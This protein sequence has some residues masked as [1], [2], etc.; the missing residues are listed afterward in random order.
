MSCRLTFVCISSAGL[1]YVDEVISHFRKSPDIQPSPL[2]DIHISSFYVGEAKDHS[3][4][5]EAIKK[6]ILDSDFVFLDLMGADP[7]T[8]GIIEETVREYRK[9]LALVGSGTEYLRSRTKL[10]AFEFEKFTKMMEKKA[11]GNA[12][13]MG[14]MN[15]DRMMKMAAVA[16][17]MSKSVRGMHDWLL[18]QRAWSF[19]GF[20]NIRNMLL[21]VLREY[22]GMTS[23]PAP[24]PI[25][26]YS[27]VVLFD[28]RT[29][30]GYKT[31][32]AFRKE[33][34]WDDARPTVGLLYSLRNYPYHTFNIVA[35]I[36]ERLSASWNVVPL[37]S[38]TGE[39][40]F[41]LIEKHM[42]EGLTL[43]VLWD[44][45]PFR[46]GAGPMGGSAEAGISVFRN[47][48]VPVLHPMFM[49]RRRIEEWKEELTGFGPA[50]LIIGIMLPEL[51]G[52]L[53]TIPIGGLRGVPSETIPDLS[54]LTLIPDR[55]DKFEAK[56][57]QYVSLGR[58][59][60]SDKK[61]AFILY[62]Y[63]P[64]EA[65]VGGG[66]FLDTFQ[67]VEHICGFLRESGYTADGVTASRL[68]KTFM[69]GGCCNS[70]QW[71]VDP[72]EMIFYG[73]E[74]FMPAENERLKSGF[75]ERTTS[76]WGTPTGSIMAD[77]KRFFIPG[78]VDGNIFIGLQPSRG[79]FEEPAKNYHDKV[80]PPQ[81]QY[82]AFYQ[83][84]K[85]EFKADAIIHV[86][87]HGTLEF[88]P[89]KESGMC[90]E[91]FPDYLIGSCPHFYYYYTGNPS[92]ATIAKRRT[93][94][95]LISYSGP[96][97]KRSGAYGDILALEE[98]IADYETAGNLAPVQ[99]KDLHEKILRK[100]EEMKL[101]VDDPDDV[102]SV[103]SELIRMKTALMPLGLHRIG[104]PFSEEEKCSFIS[105]ILG[106]KRGEILPLPE[107]IV[108]CVETNIPAIRREERACEI[109]EELVADHCFGTGKFVKKIRKQLPR[110][111]AGAL[112]DSLKFGEECLERLGSNHEFDGLLKCLDG[113]YLEA[114][115]GGDV[116]RDPEVF[117]TGF[118]M[119][120]F[121]ARLVPSEVAMERGREIAESTLAFFLKENG[122][123]PE[124]VS[125]VLWGLETSKTKGESIGQILHYLGVKI[126]PTQ[127][128]FQKKFEL[129]PLGEMNRPRIDVVVTICG[130]FRDMF[131][132]MIHF[133]DEVFEAVCTAEEPEEMNFMKKHSSEREAEL[134]RE[135]AE[136]DAVT[137]SR[138]R[139]FG[140]P[141]GQY[142][143]GLTTMIE[144]KAWTDES[145]IA[146]GYLSAQKH[147]YTRT[148][149][150]EA[151]RELFE[152]NLKQ[153]E[154]VSQ[155]RSSVDY[156]ITDLDHYYEYF[157][158]LSK[159]VQEVRGERPV[160]LY[161]DSSSSKI[162]TD[163][164]GKAIQISVRTRLLNPEYINGLLAHRVHGAQHLADRVENL[165][166]LS[167]TT[168]R[169]ES[170][171]FSAV[172]ETL[173]DDQ[174]MLEKLKENNTYAVADIMQRLFEAEKRGYWEASEEELQSLR[175]MYLEIEGEVEAKTENGV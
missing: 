105:A 93:H 141:E 98:L 117:P 18:L 3:S 172:K 83:W 23:L 169:V 85:E 124:T 40:K 148:R 155:V 99:K 110:K 160:M 145:E 101:I 32:H 31:F 68:E 113:R 49:N 118:N 38:Y 173:L 115:I 111:Q 158:G 152:S 5:F 62:N 72:P 114:H 77:G 123:C 79:S 44:F 41:E 27:D 102:D 151:R 48:D 26:D 8:V 140:P 66:A 165:V 162:Y 163:E 42:A 28:P 153:V 75:L 174:E 81:H 88:L 108:S 122:R 103:S 7:A 97:F 109:A 82:T 130:F 135:M 36:M 71:S 47:F 161:T 52:V 86:G 92:E 125:L 126:V 60:N 170:W 2:R 95:C 15:L 128:A 80:M 33:A 69:D 149:R 59:K 78:I 64:G 171:I 159:A 14:N 157:G 150:G 39:R 100:A 132:N 70:A 156:S 25:I 121:D 84:L 94:A 4:K 76:E 129:I 133:L 120:Q 11:G 104:K 45:L 19:A 63:P 146:Q 10:G 143:T 175:E 167:A 29:Q 139:I 6:S 20:D 142:G 9:N 58:K 106:W 54:E 91:C 35:D 17:K 56:S 65:N 22:C 137:L 164:A 90:E 134:R 136:A 1:K 67:S 168:G 50:E 119:F 74:S 37:G 89:G 51:D 96:A 116:I 13:G 21:L 34:K 154:V 131:P 166:G 55:F 46:F 30:T 73:K 43:D 144:N 87:T 127:N 61:L 112:N 12:S 57:K 24:G 138:G 107:I 147:L 53:D 16:G